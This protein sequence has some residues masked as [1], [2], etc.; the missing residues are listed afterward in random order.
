VSFSANPVSLA[1]RAGTDVKVTVTIPAGAPDGSTGV[2]TVTAASQAD[3][4]ETD[5]AILTTT[6]SWRFIYLPLVLR[7]Y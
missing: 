7:N 4:T 3:P 2:F 5:A 1:A 6:V